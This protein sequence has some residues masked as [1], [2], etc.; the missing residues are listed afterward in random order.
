MRPQPE[1][2]DDQ[3]QALLVQDEG[4]GQEKGWR[5]GEWRD[6][7]RTRGINNPQMNIEDRYETR[8]WLER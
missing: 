2:Y 1:L 8:K 3:T 6:P 7:R 4:M 5:S